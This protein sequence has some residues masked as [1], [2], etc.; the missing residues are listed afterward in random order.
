M[1][2]DHFRRVRFRAR[3]LGHHAAVE[4]DPGLGQ[5]MFQQ[6][7]GAGFGLAR[8]DQA[9][10]QVGDGFELIG[11]CGVNDQPPFAPGE[12]D[13]NAGRRRRIAPHPADVPGC[14][15]VAAPGFGIEHVQA[16]GHAFGI[17]EP[18]KPVGG[19]VE[20]G[21]EPAARLAQRPIQQRIVGT[22]EHA[23]PHLGRLRGSPRRGHA[24]TV[25]GHAPGDPGFDLGA[26]E[27]Q[28]AHGAG[29]GNA[30]GGG[31]VIDLALLDAQ[32][33]RQFLGGHVFGHGAAVLRKAPLFTR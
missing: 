30:P 16:G 9:A 10:A 32:K 5:Q 12:F 11:G 1:A 28:F 33:V 29:T 13:Q 3:G 23:G 8:H 17:G 2:G 18:F 14:V 21:R 27:Q 22:Q 24:P 4:A 31:Q 20:K 26:G 6:G 25:A 7:L 19:A 15:V